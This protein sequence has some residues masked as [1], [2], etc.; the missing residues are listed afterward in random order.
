MEAKSQW[1]ERVNKRDGTPQKKEFAGKHY[2][3]KKRVI[4]VLGSNLVL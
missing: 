4:C 2:V 1:Y 3:C